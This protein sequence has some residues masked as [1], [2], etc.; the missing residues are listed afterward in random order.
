MDIKF[1]AYY[2]KTLDR[3]CDDDN[4]TTYGNY[5]HYPSNVL[6]RILSEKGYNIIMDGE[7]SIVDMAIFFDLDESLNKKLSFRT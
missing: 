3:F 5:L 7:N 2:K 6:C 1:Y 4:D